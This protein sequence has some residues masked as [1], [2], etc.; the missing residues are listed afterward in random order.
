MRKRQIFVAAAVA[1]F[2]GAP[3]IVRGEQEMAA[4]KEQEKTI[5]DGIYLESVDLSG[6]TR[7]EAAEA[8]DRRMKE[9]TGYQIKLWMD[10]QSVSV[11]A[12]ELGVSGKNEETIAQAAAIGQAGNVIKR[13]KVKKDL[14][15]E[16]IQLPLSNQVDEQAVRTA[17][18]TYCSPLNREAKDY[19]LT[20]ENGKFQVQNGERGV[21]LKL[22]DSVPLVADYLENQWQ[23]GIGNVELAV[24]I[25][26]PR[27]S[28]EE[29]SRVKDLLGQGSTD[30]SS[31]S[32]ARATNITNGTATLN[33]RVLYPG[34]SISVCN[35]MMP[36]TEENGYELAPSY[37][38]GTTVES[39]GGGIC[40]VSTTL[41]LAVLR[42][43][44]EV[45]ERHNHSMIVGYVKPSMDAAIAEGAKDFQFRNNLEAP[46]YIEGYAAGG[47]LGFAI[48]G[49][50]Y[51]PENR[52]VTYE[53]ETLET[54]E[55]D[56]ELTADPELGFGVTQMTQSP[57]TGYR[58]KLWKVVT[59][60]GKEVSRE[61]VNS[62]T[63]L[64]SPTKYKVGVKTDNMEA[65]NAMYAAIASND[66]NKV[67][68]VTKQY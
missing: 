21:T 59:E 60:D 14:E 52:K 49:E 51:R 61:E 10:D 8:A 68:E 23:D 43:E 44:L 7:E 22:E 35:S 54:I 63:Y 4:G 40:Q 29:L 37:A 19:G 55:P 64:M 6:M 17:L 36:F 65:S 16:P 18:E 2:L 20:R 39:F 24:E 28:R 34:D 3:L 32:A 66:L 33:G 56:T 67:Y 57:H 9:I 31:S 46:V 5:L 48:Y 26:E 42:A 62:S 27:G 58:A 38:N 25:T 13:Y 1:L 47:S 11:S 50:E 30:Y 45:T 12:A 41:Y 53:S 15:E